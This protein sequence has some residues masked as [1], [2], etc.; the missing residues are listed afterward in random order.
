MERAIILTG[1]GSH[2]INVPEMNVTFQFMY[3]TIQESLHVDIDSGHTYML[4]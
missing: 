3:D 1:D 2:S 4:E